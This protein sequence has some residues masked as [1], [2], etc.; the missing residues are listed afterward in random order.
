MHTHQLGSQFQ[1]TKGSMLPR[2][3][4]TLLLLLRCHG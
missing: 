2:S 1:Q 4:A 3:L